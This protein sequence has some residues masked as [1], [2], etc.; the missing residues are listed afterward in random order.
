M[1]YFLLLTGI[2]LNLC[3]SSQ[4][5]VDTTKSE[6]KNVLLEEYTGRKCSYCPEGHKIAAAIKAAN[7]DDVVLMRIH[8]G[9]Y[10]PP[11]YPNFNTIF[12]Q[13][14]ANQSEITGYPAGTINRHVFSGN[15]TSMN[16]NAWDYASNQI[17]NQTAV[18]NIGMN[19]VIDTANR[20]LFV[21]VELFYT[22]NKS[23]NSNRINVVV[24]QDNI[25]GSQ[26]GA[27]ELNP[28]DGTDEV[29]NHKHILRH[30]LFGAWGTIVDSISEGSYVRKT[31]KYTLPSEIE[32]VDIILKDL[33]IAAYVLE[34]KQEILNVT[35]MKPMLGSAIGV[36]EF[37][38]ES[39]EVYPNPTH[40]KLNV[41]F[42][43]R[44]V[45]EV[46][47][48]LH[49]LLGQTVLSEN[50]NL[51]AGHCKIQLDISEF[52]PGIYLLDINNESESKTH[53]IIIR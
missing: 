14:L 18:V 45:S 6:N 42:E 1:K 22:K 10:A 20:N 11:S 4:N 47:I 30:M 44:K 37:K 34:D 50:K 19:A 26:V 40:D 29:Y 53:K 28:A 23:V 2:V 33:D 48:K 35:H 31:I 43:I 8:T 51:S 7:P 49:N 41:E 15:S 5:L 46:S 21:E 39:L 38:I 17:L 27:S 36:T 13:V 32:G 9:Y 25:V 24:L 16:R 52:N 12:G 3:L